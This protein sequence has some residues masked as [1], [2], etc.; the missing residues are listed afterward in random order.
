MTI[1]LMV[2]III[3]YLTNATIYKLQLLMF[4]I[5]NIYF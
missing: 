4:V 5:C 1:S 3:E 2:V